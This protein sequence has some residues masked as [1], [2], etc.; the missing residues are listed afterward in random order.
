[1]PENYKFEDYQA[2]LNQ[3]FSI[4]TQP[5][6]WVAATLVEASELDYQYAVEGEAGR[7]SFSIVFRTQG[8][9]QLTQRIYTVR[10]E[11]MGERQ[12]FLVPLEPDEQGA[13]CEAVFT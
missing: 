1:M 2:R 6:T 5:G 4:E 9:A 8:E 7:R 13:R 12:I 10:H 11:E 3:E